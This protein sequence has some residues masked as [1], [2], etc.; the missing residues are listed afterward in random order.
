MNELFGSMQMI[1]SL[2]A[3]FHGMLGSTSTHKE[4]QIGD[5]TQQEQLDNVDYTIPDGNY[6]NDIN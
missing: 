2:L 1:L 5:V 3:P 6:H 4:I